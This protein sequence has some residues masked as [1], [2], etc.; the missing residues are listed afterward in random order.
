MDST[1]LIADYSLASAASKGLLEGSRR[2]VIKLAVPELVLLE[3]VHK[4]RERVIRLAD[5]ADAV[6]KDAR[7]LGLGDLQVEVPA[8]Q[9]ESA[10]YEDALRTKLKDS[11]AVILSIPDISHEVLVVKAIQRSAP[12]AEKGTGYRD[13]LIWESVKEVLRTDL[14]ESVVFV[15]ANKADFGNSST[16]IRQGLLDELTSESISHDRFVVVDSPAAAA[17]ET[18]EHAQRL[19]D[20]FENLLDL[21]DVVREAFFEQVVESADL[22]LPSIGEQH[23]SPDRHVKFLNVS[24]L[25]TVNYFK[26]FR[27]WLISSGKIGVEFEAEADAD[28]SFE[29][30]VDTPSYY[31]DARRDPWP[32]GVHTDSDT[33]TASL[34]GQLEF[35]ESTREITLDG[36]SI[37]QLSEP[38]TEF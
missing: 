28:V 31:H 30:E 33:V 11:A 36:V 13:A 22:D 5:A 23:H 1:T 37:W 15:T 34:T 8:V 6:L 18:L 7:R 10:A 2:G 32:G 38:R 20:L 14:Q 19:L 24:D 17:A 26:A 9:E 16:G 35:D 27:S 4:W 29:F 21:D 25:Y 12:F 3:V